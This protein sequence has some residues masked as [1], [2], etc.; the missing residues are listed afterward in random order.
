MKITE[1]IEKAG[2]KY[3]WEKG[4]QLVNDNLQLNAV[5]VNDF[6][7]QDKKT[8]LFSSQVVSL[9]ADKKAKEIAPYLGKMI[10]A[11]NQ[12]SPDAYKRIVMRIFQ[13]IEVPEDYEGKFFDL[14]I[15]FLKSMN[16][17]IAV[18]AFAMTALRKIC[19]KYPDLKYELIPQ[20]EQLVT[21]KVSAGIV[22][23]GEKELKRLRKI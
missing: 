1:L 7:K 6:L 18:K 19:E 3:N 9:L 4:F 11:L 15:S 12:H 2:G 5:V 20:I 8:I 21:E 17:P 16:E 22:N 23:R 13:T 10:D 14:G